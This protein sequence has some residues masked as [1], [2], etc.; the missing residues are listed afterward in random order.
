MIPVDKIYIMVYTFEKCICLIQM[1]VYL[2]SNI[3]GIGIRNNQKKLKDEKCLIGPM[4]MLIG[5][6]AKSQNMT[7]VTN[8]I[9]EFARIQGLKVENWV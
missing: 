9:G 2:C 1:S 6:H 4:D 5:A 8:N 3:G 7:L